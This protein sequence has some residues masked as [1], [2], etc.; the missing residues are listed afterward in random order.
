[1]RDLEFNILRSLKVKCNSATELPIYGFLLM[2]NTC[3]KMA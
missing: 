2:F 3:S 1:M